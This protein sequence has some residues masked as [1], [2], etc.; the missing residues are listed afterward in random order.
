MKILYN[1]TN[2][3]QTATLSLKRTILSIQVHISSVNVP[4]LLTRH[5]TQQQGHVLHIRNKKL[6]LNPVNKNVKSRSIKRRKIQKCTK[7]AQGNVEP[8][9]PEDHQNNAS[10]IFMLPQIKPIRT[11][12]S[13]H[14]RFEYLL[15]LLSVFERT[16]YQTKINIITIR[17]RAFDIQQSYY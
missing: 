12:Q 9:Q 3:N 14:Q 5:D 10:L 13:L 8:T 7:G 16:A 11:S 17:C 4:K 6:H 2:S 15:L 1:H